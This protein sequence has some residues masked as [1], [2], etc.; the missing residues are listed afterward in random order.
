MVLSNSQAL[1][2][3]IK[4]EIILLGNKRLTMMWKMRIGP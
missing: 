1:N 2:H 4:K 3:I